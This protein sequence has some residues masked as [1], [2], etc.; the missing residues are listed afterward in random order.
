M[1]CDLISSYDLL[2][3]VA[4]FSSTSFR[5]FSFAATMVWIVEYRH[6]VGGGVDKVIE[7]KQLKHATTD[8]ARARAWIRIALNEGTLQSFVASLL[9]NTSLLQEHYDPHAFLRDEEQAAKLDMLLAGLSFA[10]PVQL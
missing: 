7:H 10:V 9:A 8:A 6:W 3:F 5:T 2:T 1:T 4:A